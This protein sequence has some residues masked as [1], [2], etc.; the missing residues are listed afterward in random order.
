VAIG[1]AS[2]SG[3]RRLLGSRTATRTAVYRLFDACGRLLYVGK[4]IDLRKRLGEHRREQAWWPRVRWAEVR[5]FSDTPVA[6]D[7]ELHSIREEGPL[8][9]EQGR[10]G[11]R[12]RRA[13]PPLQEPCAPAEIIVFQA[14]A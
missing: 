8:L 14:A 1:T 4:T 12:Q 3:Q 10:G 13:T 11:P 9:N 2:R 6:E 7:E 5:W